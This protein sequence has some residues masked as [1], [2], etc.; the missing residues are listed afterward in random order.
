MT[1][2]AIDYL[3]RGQWRHVDDRQ[4]ISWWV[5]AQCAGLDFRRRPFRAHLLTI[6]QDVPAI[7][8]RQMRPAKPRTGRGLS[9]AAP[10]VTL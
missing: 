10:T 9:G 7:V 1:N 2:D 3:V 6:A 4:R 5:A 8:V